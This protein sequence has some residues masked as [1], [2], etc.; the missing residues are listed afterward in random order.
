MYH[1]VV[2]VREV[3]HK[4]NLIAFMFE[5]SSEDIEHDERPCVADV[6]IVIY[7]RAAGIEADMPG[8]DRVEGLLLA[9]QIVEQYYTH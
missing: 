4:R 3:L 1:L 8:L 6:E 9:G 2:N 5:P 7:R